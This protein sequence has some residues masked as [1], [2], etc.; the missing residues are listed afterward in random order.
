MLSANQIKDIKA[1]AFMNKP[2]ELPGVCKIYPKT[3]SE[4]VEL[5]EIEYN[6]R[7]ETL[8][9]TEVKI[10]ELLKEKTGEEVPLEE[11]DVLSYLLE[12]ADRSDMFSL[13]LQTMFSTFIKEDILFLPKIN[14][15]LIGNPSQRRLITPKNFRDFQDILRIQNRRDI[16]EPPP[17]NESFGQRKMRLLR[18]KVAAVKKKQAQKKGDGQTLEELL[19]IATVFGIDTNNCTLYAFY[20]LLRMYQAKEKWD[21][22][23]QMLCAGASSEKIKTKYWGESLTDN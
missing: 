5:G 7:L 21:Q 14:S 23:I 8:L 20:S 18:E 12:S 3:M 22:D 10:G 1:Q 16:E 2:S 17:E 13:E 11:I 15:V 19:E 6:R 9:L 4:I